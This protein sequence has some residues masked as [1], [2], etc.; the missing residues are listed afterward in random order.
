MGSRRLGAAE[1]APEW[2]GALVGR[3]ELSAEW[4]GILEELP[5]R[6]FLPDLIWPFD[7][8]T[9][10]YPA[11]DRREDPQAW[12][13]WAAA[14]TAI[15]TQWD[16]GAH[17]GRTPGE[18]PTSSAPTPSIVGV[19]LQDLDVRPG[20]RVLDAGTGTGWTTAL[21]ARRAGA[22]NVTGVEIDPQVAEAAARRFSAIGIDAVVVTGDGGQGRPVNAPYDRVQSTYAVRRVPA[23]WIEQTRPGGLIVVP[24][25]TRYANVNAVARL[26]VDA[27]GAARGRFTRLVEFLLDRRQRTTSPAHEEYLPGGAWPATVRE[28]GTTLPLDELSAAEFVIGLRVPDIAHTV[29][30]DDQGTALFWL[31][32]LTD[33]S[34]AVAFFCQDGRTEFDVLQDGPRS[35]W[36]EVEA[37][38]RWWEREHRPAATRFGLTAG[39]DGHQVWLDSPDRIVSL[40]GTNSELETKA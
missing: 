36:D 37:A 38:C 10:A 25:G 27:D 40:A 13:R 35:L 8:E 12:E 23:A 15:V 21:L 33:R 4:G 28:S 17:A 3:G 1:G 6:L 2:L 29:S 18:T 9:G 31:H 26:R 5:R 30:V 32:G 7:P 19:M 14:D 24:W 22:G 20:H 16:D 39:P 11:V 34:W